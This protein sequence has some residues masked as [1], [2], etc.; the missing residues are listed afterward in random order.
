MGGGSSPED[1]RWWGDSH[2]TPQ[3]YSHP[4]RP[5]PHRPW[6][7][8]GAGP[9]LHTRPGPTWVPRWPGSSPHT[10]PAVRGQGWAGL[11]ARPGWEGSRGQAGP[12][13]TRQPSP[14]PWAAAGLEKQVAEGVERTGVGGPWGARGG[15]SRGEAQE[16]D[17]AGQPTMG[18]GGRVQ[19]GDR[20]QEGGPSPGGSGNGGAL[21]R[22]L[23]TRGKRAAPKARSTQNI[24]DSRRAEMD[25]RGVV[26]GA[27]K[28][29][30]EGPPPSMGAPSGGDGG[31]QELDGGERCTTA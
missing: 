1:R 13:D 11:S 8:S 31:A 15:R 23:E 18:C 12:E 4:P 25:S 21:G 17:D 19:P 28:G 6:A 9:Q 10:C 3:P 22:S 24:Q 29:S 14:S 27:G 30:G 2:R 16:H 5:L 7:P 20:G 26:D